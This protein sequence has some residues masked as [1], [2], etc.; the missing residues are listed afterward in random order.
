VDTFQRIERSVR[1]IEEHILDELTLERVAAE[2]YF[3]PYHF[4]RIFR[5]M[6]GESV[7]EY[8]RKRRLALAADELLGSSR[9]I[10][11]LA[12]DYHF[13]SHEAFTRSFKR[14][15]GLAPATY[16]KNG[17]RLTTL[18]KKRLDG[19]RLKHL[20]K[21]VTME[22]KI[23]RKEGFKVVGMEV[24][25]TLRSNWENRDIFH[26]WA[27]FQTRIGEIVDRTDPAVSYGIC[28]DID[29]EKPKLAEMT[30]DT[31]YT[32]LVSV[33]VADLDH[34]PEGMVGRIVPGRTYAVFTHIGPLFPNYLQQTYD[35]I[36]GTWLPHS[37]RELDGGWDFEVYDVR[38]TGVDDPDSEFD[39]YVPIK[40]G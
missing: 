29:N 19:E 12:L 11:D 37:D 36:Y 40:V 34:I 3:S 30:E 2:A 17:V 9:S 32:D 38:F 13:Q 7:D 16:R 25:T 1:F 14:A 31:E 28:G 35:Y 24:T 5:A 21:G 33:E 8:I 39:I 23:V 15:Y 20:I 4:H 22:P 6:A 10:L 27:R 18:L 26:L